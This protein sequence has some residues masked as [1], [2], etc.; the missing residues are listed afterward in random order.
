M[1]LHLF[2]APLSAPPSV[3]LQALTSHHLR[4][5][6]LLALVLCYNI[7]DSMRYLNRLSSLPAPAPTS[8]TPTTSAPSTPTRLSTPTQPHLHT[9]TYSSPKTRPSPSTPTSSSTP[10]FRSSSLGS[11]TPPSPQTPSSLSRSAS[12]VLRRSFVGTPGGS[13]GGSPLGR[14]VSVGG[15]DAEKGGL[16]AAFRARHSPVACELA[17]CFAVVQRS[18]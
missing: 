17:L 7:I 3:L 6:S 11:P 4:T 18:T 14:S 12:A 15:G 2:G 9:P 13:P 10:L 8:P 1:P 16:V 5:E